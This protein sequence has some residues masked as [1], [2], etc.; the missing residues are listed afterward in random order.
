MGLGLK[1]KINFQLIILSGCVLTVAYLALV[2]LG[3]L[4][5]NSIRS[6][7]LGEPGAYFTSNNFLKAYLSPDFFPLLKNSFVYGL[8]NCLL[9]FFLGTSLV[10]RL[11]GFLQNN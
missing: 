5:F 1:N 10:Q 8:G 9:T 11:L 6:A 4:L 3:M 2:P 7:P